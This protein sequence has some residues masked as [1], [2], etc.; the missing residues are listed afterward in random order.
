MLSDVNISVLTNVIGAV[1]SGGQVYGKRNYAA[2]TPPFKNSPK[3]Y[4]IT[5]GWAQN[6]GNEAR[7]LMR[8]I[9]EADKDAFRKVDNVGIEKMLS[10]DWVALRWNPTAVEKE[11]LVKLIDSSVGRACQDALFGNLMKKF[12]EYCEEKYTKDPKAIMMYCE[13][14]H[15]GG[16]GPANRIFNR[17]AGKYDLDTI[18]AALA[19]DQKDNSS[20]NQ[21]GDV[22]YWS[23]HLKCR[24][25]IDRYAVVDEENQNG[26]KEEPMKYNPKVLIKI[27]EDEIGYL[28]KKSNDN[29]DS[30]TE[31]AGKGNFTKYWRDMKPSFQG[32]AWCDCFVDWCFTKAYGKKAA[33]ELQCGGTY[34]FYTPTS[35]GRYKE[36]G[37]WHVSSPEMGDQIFFKNSERICHTGIVTGADS[38]YV[39]TIEGNTSGASGVIS[40]GGGVC[41]K[42][43]SLKSGYIAGYGRPNYGV[44]SETVKEGPRDI[45]KGMK[46]EDVKEMQKMLINAGYSCGKAGADGDFGNDTEKALKAFQKDAGL[47]ANG[48]YDKK[49]DLALL[50]TKKVEEPKKEVKH[51]VVNVE[52]LNVRSGPGKE[53]KNLSSYPLLKK[54][55]EV[56]ILEVKGDWYKVLIAGKHEGYVSAK[57]L[58]VD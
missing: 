47:E 26:E 38:A 15:L 33:L 49:T 3:E 34:D 50:N 52:L 55:N 37:Q 16:F 10:K 46:G 1:E 39:Y 7:A 21:V 44:E 19:A 35:A 45:L 9:F 8:L 41:R 36:K 28:E 5:L 57:F 32:Q 40:N 30:K 20:S 14:R 54:N 6:Y 48:V 11:V 13:I 25:F 17:C 23:R 24:Q 31:N 29:L 51:G 27:A 12:I 53:Y 18:M 4:T 43:Y 2:Y 42:K 58:N 56:D 22:K